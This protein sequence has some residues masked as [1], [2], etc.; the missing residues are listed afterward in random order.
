MTTNNLTHQAPIAVYQMGKVGSETIINS[1]NHL[2]LP[3]PIYH[4][5]IL[6]KRNLNQVIPRYQ[7]QDL[8]LTLQLKHSQKLRNYLESGLDPKLTVITAVREPI[9]QFISAFFQN[10]KTSN[11]EFIDSDGTWNEAKIYTHLSARLD[12]YDPQTAW[13]CNWF[14]NDFKAALNIDIY[15]HDFDRKLGYTKFS[16]GKIE[17]LALQ[18]EKSDNWD[19]YLSN[20]LQLSQPV[21]IV[22]SNFSDNKQYKTVY[23]T[24]LRG[25]K[26]PKQTLKAIYQSKYCRHF[27][28]DEDLEMFLQRWSKSQ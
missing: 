26:I 23:N 1:L 27:Y 17:L 3:V 2:N 15:Q 4:I 16:Q 14:D 9:S 5:H 21:K 20:F 18:L 13:N 24:I 11:P 28:S 6:S 7:Q 19:K 22:K 12:N 8:E 25:I 10:I